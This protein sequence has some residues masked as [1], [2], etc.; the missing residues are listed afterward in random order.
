MVGFG[1]KVRKENMLEEKLLQDI[2]NALSDEDAGILIKGI[3]RYVNTGNS[4]LTG[5]LK[6]IFLSIKELI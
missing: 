3:F 6:V 4:G 5:Y 2:F 1:L